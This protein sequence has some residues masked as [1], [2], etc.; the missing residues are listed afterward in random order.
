MPA[1]LRFVA[2]KRPEDKDEAGDALYWPRR[3]SL[4]NA[5]MK[6]E[7]DEG[8]SLN[9]ALIEVYLPFR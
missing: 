9:G 1:R 2:H 4:K 3:T 7:T 6:P 5:S 8:R